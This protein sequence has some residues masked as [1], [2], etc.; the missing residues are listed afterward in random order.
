MM[1]NRTGSY[2]L[3]TMVNFKRN[4]LLMEFK[5]IFTAGPGTGR[6]F[7]PCF[8]TLLLAL[9]FFTGAHEGSGELKR[10]QMKLYSSNGREIRLDVEIAASERD[11]QKG[12]MYRTSLPHNSGMLFVFEKEKRLSFWMKNTYIPLDIAFIDSHGVIK[13][14]YQ[15]RPLDTSVFYNSSTEVRYALEVNQWWFE[16]N[17]I[18]AGS[19]TGLNGC[20]GK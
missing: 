2:G 19:K 11:R 8:Y 20:I 7:R 16:K 14:I 15:M 12:L 4:T 1:R 6:A 17:G 10:C 9:I 18:S 5:S 3:N 13:D